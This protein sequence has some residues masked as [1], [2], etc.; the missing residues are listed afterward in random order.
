M[1]QCQAASCPAMR[2]VRMCACAQNVVCGMCACRQAGAAQ[3]DTCRSWPHSKVKARQ[4]AQ[5]LP[6]QRV[7][8][9]PACLPAY[10]ACHECSQQNRDQLDKS[11]RVYFLRHSIC[12]PGGQT[13]ANQPY[14][15]CARMQELAITSKGLRLPQNSMNISR[16]LTLPLDSTGLVLAVL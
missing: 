2:H 9:L 16:P 13:P 10:Y 12:F 7:L 6:L 5:C 4:G 11:C 1:H 3:Q 14:C 15:T 8:F